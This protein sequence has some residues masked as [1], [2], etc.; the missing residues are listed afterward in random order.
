[1]QF[2]IVNKK[3]RKIVYSFS[4]QLKYESRPEYFIGIDGKVRE[5]GRTESDFNDVFIREDLEIQIV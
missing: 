4:K 2:I 3:S 5:F 1:M